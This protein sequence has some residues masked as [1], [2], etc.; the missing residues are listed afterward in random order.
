MHTKHCD[1]EFRVKQALL[2]QHQAQ[3]PPDCVRPGEAS[4]RGCQTCAAALECR[5][6]AS[7]GPSNRAGGLWQGQRGK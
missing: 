6:E 2:A 4:W 7:N 5:R 3:A 1:F